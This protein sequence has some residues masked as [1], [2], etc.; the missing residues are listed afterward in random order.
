MKSSDLA[1]VSQRARLIPLVQTPMR[2]MA[3]AYTHPSGTGVVTPSNSV[4]RWLGQ[5]YST[6]PWLYAGSTVKGYISDMP[7]KRGMT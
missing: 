3:T 6:A 4:S 1:V 7:Q 5:P 2:Y